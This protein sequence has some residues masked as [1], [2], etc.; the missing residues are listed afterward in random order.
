M[1]GS[2]IFNGVP[3]DL[4]ADIDAVLHKYMDYCTDNRGWKKLAARGGIRAFER[5]LPNR[6]NM[7]K[8]I[9]T[10]PYN[11]K[12]VFQVVINGKRRLEY[13]TNIRVGERLKRY[14]NHTFLD[15]LQYRAVWPTAARDFLICLHWRVITLPNE[16]IDE[17][18]ETDADTGA[19][20]NPPGQSEPMI[21]LVA[22]SYPNAYDLKPVSSN[23]VRAHLTVNMTLLKCKNNN[24]ECEMTRILGYDL[25]GS[26]PRSLSKSVLQQQSTLSLVLEGYMR[27]SQSPDDESITSGAITSTIL[28]Q[29][30]E[31]LPDD[32]DGIDS[33]RRQLRFTDRPDG[34]EVRDDRSG[35]GRGGSIVENTASGD[36]DDDEE[37]KPKEASILDVSILLLT[38]L[39]IWH[40][41][42]DFDATLRGATFLLAAFIVLRTVVLD[43]LGD[44]LIKPHSALG[45]VGPMT[46]HFSVNLRAVLHYLSDK[47]DEYEDGEVSVVHLVVKAAAQ[48]L[49]E[50]KQMNCSKVSVPFLGIR[51]CFERKQIDVSVMNVCKSAPSQMVTVRDAQNKTVD[52]IVQSLVKEERLSLLKTE[53]MLQSVENAVLRVLGLRDPNDDGSCLVVT[54]PDQDMSEINID[55]VP[56]R[57]FNVVV[58]IGGVRLSR[59]AGNEFRSSRRPLPRPQPVLAMSLGIDNP[60]CGVWE[61]RK[62]TERLHQLIEYPDD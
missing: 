25:G 31:N 5:R 54:S 36:E 47:K 13:E 59:P 17:A 19:E 3:H 16:T 58:V 53:S 32:A 4:K 41:L 12:H 39:I 11:P 44:P 14:N 26:V 50:T 37:D 45:D 62:F 10:I 52:E 2:T 61:S 20:A 33:V 60:A 51:N 40:I 6:T 23:H 7:I 24:T 22:F 9:S 55:I 46:C 29:I 43:K 18:D 1:E 30:V 57:G 21:V 48:A 38:P 35:Q 15:Y 34:F 42:K 49:D 56:R 28:S 27:R 8:S